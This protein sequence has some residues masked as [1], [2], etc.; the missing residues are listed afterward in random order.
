[1]LVT[2]V[3]VP[4]AANTGLD[5]DR[6]E[7]VEDLPADVARRMLEVGTA[8]EPSDAELAAYHKAPESAGLDNGGTLPAGLPEVRNDTGKP[9][10]VGGAA[11]RVRASGKSPSPDA[12]SDDA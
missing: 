2:I 9:E 6:L 12:S 8:R 10:P 3:A 11:S 7:K 4:N 1:M 5:V